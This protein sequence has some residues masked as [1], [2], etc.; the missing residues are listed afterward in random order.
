MDFFY[1]F[2]MIVPGKE[3]LSDA[4]LQALQSKLVYS[5]VSSVRAFN[6][7]LIQNPKESNLNELL[8]VSKE[9]QVVDYCAGK[10]VNGGYL[11]LPRPG[12][13]SPWSSK[14]TD[15]AQICGLSLKRI[16][17]GIVYFFNGSNIN[18]ENIIPHIHDRMTHVV[19]TT[20][21]SVKEY[22]AVSDPRPLKSVDLISAQSS[23]V[24][25]RDIL[26]NANKRWGLALAEDEIDYL[27]DAF[28]NPP[29]GS[30]PRNPTDVELMVNL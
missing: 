16:E 23:S 5:G 18:K 6:V 8:E 22:F 11:V 1:P 24:K 3:A 25:P 27:A 21:P 20:L 17:R 15:I 4:Q 10:T 7:Y 9:Q 14:A 26:S 29:D 28:L 2:K 30:Q 19:Y 13:I 12:T